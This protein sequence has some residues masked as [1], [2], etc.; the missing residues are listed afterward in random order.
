M[1]NIVICCDGMGNEYS[2]NNTNVVETCAIRHPI[3]RWLINSGLFLAPIGILPGGSGRYSCVSPLAGNSQA[4]PCLKASGAA[5]KWDWPVSVR[6]CKCH[7]LTAV[8]CQ[9]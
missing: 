2:E 4:R 5:E 3:T 8:F 6:V 7:G 1:K 9:C